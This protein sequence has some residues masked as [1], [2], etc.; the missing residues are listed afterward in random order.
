MAAKF[1]TVFKVK[2]YK[3]SELRTFDIYLNR[4]GDTV[5]TFKNKNIDRDRMHLNYSIIP[6]EKPSAAIKARIEELAKLPSNRIRIKKSTNVVC[7]Y[8]ITAG[9]EFFQFNDHRAFFE[10][11]IR[12]FEE[13]HGRENIIMAVVH[14]DEARPHMHVLA[15]PVA[16]DGALSTTNF[17]KDKNA[18]PG[19]ARTRFYEIVGKHWNLTRGNPRKAT[20]PKMRSLNLEQLHRLVNNEEDRIKELQEEARRRAAEPAKNREMVLAGMP[21]SHLLESK[22]A[23]QERLTG[24]IRESVFPLMDHK[25]AVADAALDMNDELLQKATENLMLI[26]KNQ[27]LERRIEDILAGR[28]TA[29]A[30][31]K[32]S[33]KGRT[34]EPEGK[35]KSAEPL[36]PEM[37]SGPAEEIGSPVR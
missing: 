36:S 30:P 14:R 26:R 10:D 8:M 4:S 32:E 6:C 34:A 23:F 19:V 12:F 3:L 5:R 17:Y 11:A 16:S 27:D 20:D 13:W 35:E 1:K 25:Q 22:K 21:E 28:D 29:A 24:Y 9:G 33:V 2:G 15:M 37:L 31:E 18:D 7:H